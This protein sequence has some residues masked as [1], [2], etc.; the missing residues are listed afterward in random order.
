MNSP[1]PRQETSGWLSS[2]YCSHVVPERG[3]PP[4]KN[5]W[6]RASCAIAA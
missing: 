3:A 1:S 6:H 5:N 4:M 2:R